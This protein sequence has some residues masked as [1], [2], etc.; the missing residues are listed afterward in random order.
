[1][2]SQWGI[3]P[4]PGNFQDADKYPGKLGSAFNISSTSCGPVGKR[5]LAVFTAASKMVETTGHL[6]VD[7]IVLIMDHP[8]TQNDWQLGRVT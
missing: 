7:D 6:N 1:M 5:N 8:L 2:A 3:H 4:P